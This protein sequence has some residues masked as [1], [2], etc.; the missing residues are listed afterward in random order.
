MRNLE[1][2]GHIAVKNRA[3]TNAYCAPICFFAFFF[4]FAKSLKQKTYKKV[5]YSEKI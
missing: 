2:I 5:Q 4:S 3:I 1:N